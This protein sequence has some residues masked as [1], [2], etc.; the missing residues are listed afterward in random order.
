M[1]GAVLAHHRD[2]VVDAGSFGLVEP[3]DAAADAADQL[4]DPGDLFLG[5]GGVGAGPLV[6]P[7]K[8]GGQPFA[9]AQQVV[10]VGLQ[11]GQE[12]DVGAEVVAAGA[13]E[14]DRAGAATGLDVR[15]FGAATVGD[16]DLADRVAGMFGVQ[17]GLGTLSSGARTSTWRSLA[18]SSDS[19]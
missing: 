16:G 11:V 15:G 10:E 6:D 19:Q 5:G 8:R 4:P 2:S 13:A 7:V 1:S 9:G 17:Q 14:P 18:G 12:R 3:G